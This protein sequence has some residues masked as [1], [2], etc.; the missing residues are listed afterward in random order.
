MKDFE[1]LVQVRRQIP[2]V[3]TYNYL[4]HIAIWVTLLKFI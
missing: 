4:E 2:G 1:N 3:A